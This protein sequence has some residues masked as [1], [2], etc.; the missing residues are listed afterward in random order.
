MNTANGNFMEKSID[1]ANA[2]I[3]ILVG[4]K[5]S[6]I[7]VSDL[8][9]T[10]P[11]PQ[12][13][14]PITP[15]SFT[16]KRTLTV[17]EVAAL[18]SGIVLIPAMPGYRTAIT[19]GTVAT[20]AGTVWSGATSISFIQD[21]VPVNSGTATYLYTGALGVSALNPAAITQ[22][23]V[24]FP[25]TATNIAIYSNPSGANAPFTN[26]VGGFIQLEI[27]LNYNVVKI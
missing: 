25:T 15:G 7:K 18:G 4:G 24:P 2:T 20:T 5:L 1:P 23:A 16:L 22:T 10:M 11:A 8:F 21:A 9:A 12:G 19:S 27:L 26:P 3:D 13:V 6:T 14:V 17:A